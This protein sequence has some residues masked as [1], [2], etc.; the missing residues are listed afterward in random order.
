MA[1]AEIKKNVSKLVD[2][3]E[4]LDSLEHAMQGA[5]FKHRKEL[6]DEI[7]DLR[8]HTEAH[9]L[10]QATLTQQ[11]LYQVLEEWGNG[12]Q[13]AGKWA[14]IAVCVLALLNIVGIAIHFIK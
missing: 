7:Q 11:F 6:S 2:I 3:P 1:D 8:L 10:S 4:K 14:I 12:F 13:K 9:S 5:F